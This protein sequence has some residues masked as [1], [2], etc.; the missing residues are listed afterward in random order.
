MSPSPFCRVLALWLAL[1]AWAPISTGWAQVRRVKYTNAEAYLVV[2]CLADDLVHFEFGAGSGPPPASPLAV[3]PMVA[4]T[5]F[6]GPGQFS[7]DGHGTLATSD[8]RLEVQADSLCLTVTDTTRQPPLRL[9]TFCPFDLD[10]DFPGLALSPE[11]FTQVY[12]LGQQFVAPGNSE[13]DWVGRT[14]TPGNEFGN[15]MVYWNDGAVGN[16][17]FPIAYPAGAGYDCY[18]LFLDNAYR[19]EWDFTDSPW[20]VRMG[21]GP[22]RGY[23]LGGPDLADLRRDYLELTGRPP[24]PPRK[25][26]GLWVSE[27]GFDDWA[28][29]GDKLRTLREGAFPVDGFILDCFWYGG[30]LENSDD[31]PMGRLTWDTVHFPDPTGQVDA[32]REDGIGLLLIEQPYVGRNLPEHAALADQGFLARDCETCPP[33]YLDDNPWWGK[34]GMIDWTD[35]A[36]GACWHDWKREPLGELGIVGHWTDLGEPEMFS[37]GSWY[38][39]VEAGRHAHADVHNL[40]NL[41]WSQSIA[42]G[43]LRHGRTERPFILSRSGAPGSQRCGVAMW[44]GD[45]GSNLSSLITHFNA[46]L[47]M[48]MSGM[49]YYGADV[50]GFHHWTPVEDPDE[51]YTQ[52]FANAACIDIPL[53]P[54][55]MNLCNCWETAPD[56][57]GDP[58]S[59]RA[60]LR[61]RYE[62]GPYYYSLAH[63]AWLYGE[64]VIPPL[65]YYFQDDPAVRT[66]GHQKLI[67]PSLMAG[68]VAGFGETERWMYLPAGDWVDWHSLEPIHSGGGWHGPFPEYRDGLFRLPLLARAGAIIPLMHVDEQTMNML[69]QRR[70]GNR[71]DELIV[72][73]FAAP[74]PT[75]F[76]LYEDDGVSVAYQQG[77]V[78]TTEITQ[79]QAGSRVVVRIAPSDGTYDGAVNPR[80][81]RVQLVTDG[82]LPFVGATLGGRNLPR[83]AT[84]QDLAA[85][86]AGCAEAG[87]RLAL[88]HS[89]Q[90]DP[91]LAK[92]FVCCFADAA[93]AAAELAGVNPLAPADPAWSDRDG[94]GRLTAGDLMRWRRGERKR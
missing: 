44:S 50:G 27:Y 68:V 39:G 55:T 67:G 9:S 4:R 77:A 57:I 43:Y 16:T 3:T 73:V 89:G 45:I 14:R 51:L 49:D 83:F 2:E 7:N 75:A 25:M 41:K 38:H 15:A 76:T 6:P 65:V 74:A 87:D 5:Q 84:P 1:A 71:R 61:L 17:Q 12:G 66:M 20:T 92:D 56:R 13:G 58:A 8:L 80:D 86:P 70:D 24:V 40:L 11:S 63:R 91:G 35:D 78:R 93:L 21:G 88:A 69:G 90:A 46:Q 18:A 19:Q 53:R 23:L 52:W 64:P 81:N 85:A 26:F 48:S 79:E 82:G 94:D 59:N 72:R 34:G 28:E 60:N 42:A 33:T 36:A 10:S 30:L 62:L 31:T 54:H 29:V 22:V 37:P 47:H 32:F